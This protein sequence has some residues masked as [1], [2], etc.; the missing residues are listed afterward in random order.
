MT[1][2]MHANLIVCKQNKTIESVKQ[3]NEVSFISHTF[4]PHNKTFVVSFFMM[5]NDIQLRLSTLNWY[6]IPMI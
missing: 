1:Q 2:K 6:L 4:T 5:E 3:K